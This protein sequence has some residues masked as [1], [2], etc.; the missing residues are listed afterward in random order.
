MGAFLSVDMYKDV[1]M[2]LREKFT[3]IMV[4]IVPQKYRNNVIYEKGRLVLYATL[5]KALYRFLLSAFLFNEH[6]VSN[7]IGKWFELN[8]YEE[9][10]LGISETPFTTKTYIFEWKM[11]RFDTIKIY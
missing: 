7:M 1:K 3:K 11:L 9:I 4:N 8:A 10:H 5:K 6:L 2:E